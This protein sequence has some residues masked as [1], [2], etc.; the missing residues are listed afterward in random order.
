MTDENTG[1]AGEEGVAPASEAAPSEEKAEATSIEEDAG[2]SGSE[3]ESGRGL[4]EESP[5]LKSSFTPGQPASTQS[6]ILVVLFATMLI[7]GGI[8]VASPD[9]SSDP[10]VND[11]E[12]FD[13]KVA[14]NMDLGYK[15]PFLSPGI[16][17]P[18]IR[19]VA[20]TRF[21]AASPAIGISVGDSHRVYPLVTVRGSFTRTGENGCIVNDNLGGKLITVTNDADAGKIR[22]FRLETEARR[23]K[24]ELWLI[25]MGDGG[26]MNLGFDTETT[27]RQDSK[28][29][30]DLEDH[31]FKK[32]TLAEWRVEHPET[33][34]YVGEFLTTD[35]QM[36]ASLPYMT[37]EERVEA[38]G[39]IAERNRK[40]KILSPTRKKR[41]GRKTESPAITQ[42]KEP[43]VKNP[44]EKGAG[45]TNSESA[46]RVNR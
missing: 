39:I 24:I 28:Q 9:D 6:K 4:S 3:N 15:S 36:E 23:K 12:G 7:V 38:D 14:R 20:E 11:K 43:A 44:A 17:E 8:Y 29:I 5:S 25:G 41:R 42:P 26:G 45:G 27:F 31:P 22:V 2:G 40:R 37:T 18:E 35:L 1:L 19:A 34:V 21:A 33:D 30:P 32:S 16:N 13:E 46:S 10:L